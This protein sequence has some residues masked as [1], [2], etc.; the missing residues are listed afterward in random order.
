M[1]Y[2]YTSCKRVIS[3]VLTELDVQEKQKY[4]SSMIEWIGEALEKIGAAPQFVVK[5]TGLDNEPLLEIVN[6]QAKLPMGLHNVLQIGYSS[7]EN[8]S[9]IPMRYGTGT[10]DYNKNIINSTN[11]NS[12]LSNNDLVNI[13]MRLYNVDYATALQALNANP[14]IKETL[15]S[16][17][18][19]NNVTFKLERGGELESNDYTYVINGNYIKTNSRSGY[20]RVTYQCIALDI[21]GYP[22][23]PDDMSYIDAIFWYINMKLLYMEWRSGRVRDSVYYDA[24]QQWNFYCK[25]AYGNALMPNQDMM[26][27]IKNSWLRI[28]PNI[29]AHSTFY[30]NVGEVETL[31][32]NK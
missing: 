32:L 17:I 14:T 7:T 26:E 29:D 15:Y 16:F 6:Y 20:L 12:D 9:F 8:G 11:I 10:Y 13:Y 22:L 19:T 31:Y 25:Q 27:S 24:R 3:K 4:L 18:N 2:R 21:D 23:I 28:I 1:V 5:T 30:S